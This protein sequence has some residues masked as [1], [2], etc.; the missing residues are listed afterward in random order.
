[1]NPEDRSTVAEV[2]P[3]TL[4]P[5]DLIIRREL[6]DRYGGGRQGGMEPSAKTPN[7]FLFTDRETGERNGYT[8]DGWAPDGT[9]HYT[10]EGP[11]GDQVMTHGNRAV[12]DHLKEGRALRLFQKEGTSVR[13]LGEFEVPDDGSHVEVAESYDAEQKDKRNVFVFRLRPVG[14]VLERDVPVSPAEPE[15]VARKVPVEVANAETFVRQHP[16]VSESIEAVRRE[17]ALV[18][19]FV[20]WL[21]KQGLTASRDAIPVPGGQLLYTDVFVNESRELLE[22]KS[23]ASREHIRV[24]LGQILDYERYVDHDALAVLVPTRP[25]QDMISLLIKHGVG[26]VWETRPGHFEADRPQAFS[27]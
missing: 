17:S 9:F 8:H 15:F 21:G 24:A 25:S 14:D 12:R 27:A 5:G 11:S 20:E 7:V 18:S 22:A 3:W 2:I 10:G 16:P 4:Q 23:S 6:H 13:Y 1:M 26:C 19:R